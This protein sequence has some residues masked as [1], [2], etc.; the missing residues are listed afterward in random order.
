MRLGIL[1]LLLILNVET[2]FAKKNKIQLVDFTML[3]RKNF[4]ALRG[5][6]E[7]N[8]SEALLAFLDNCGKIIELSPEKNIFPQIKTNMKITRDDFYAVCKIA[9][10][11]K[12]YSNKYKQVFFESFFVPY[13]VVGKNGE[14][15]LFTG[16]YIPTLRAKTRRDD[17][18]KYPIYRRPSNLNYT[19]KEINGGALEGK[20]LEIF[21]TD[22]PVDL[23]F[24]HIQGSFNVFLTDETRVVPLGFDGK[25]NHKFSPIWKFIVDNDLL[26]DPHPNPMRLKQELKKK[27]RD[28]CM[29][30]FD[31]NNSYVFFKVINGGGITGAFGTKLIPTRTMAVDNGVIPLGFP[32]WLSTNQTSGEKTKEF[33]K[34]V[35][36]NDTGSA[37]KGSI[38][39]DIFFG[40]GNFAEERA[41][42][43][44]SEGEYYLLIPER[45]VRKL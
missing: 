36:A 2:V 26:D 24:A 29:N 21:F 45:I 13:K 23:F 4:S 16:Y 19:R 32:L 8:F 39:G 27:S 7:E 43:Q 41:S 15:S 33:N 10:V 22:D 12:N 28:F 17:I 34:M 5:W 37:I 1:F 20:N 6:E 14:K 38:R 3:E 30:I 42:R 9:D 31:A 25:N 44:Y 40:Y 18:F 35:I 11:I